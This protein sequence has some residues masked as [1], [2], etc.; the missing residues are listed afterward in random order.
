MARDPKRMALYEAIRKGQTKRQNGRRIAFFRPF[1]FGRPR[2]GRT[3]RQRSLVA[4]ALKGT[5]SGYAAR[6]RSPGILRILNGAMPRLAVVA[7]GAAVV[8]VGSVRLVGGYGVRN[9]LTRPEKNVIEQPVGGT[10]DVREILPEP[11]APRIE[12]PAVEI[13][14]PVRKTEV[15]EKP[16]QPVSD[17]KPQGTNVIVIQAYKQR[18]DLEPVME[19]FA[20]NGV[21]TEIVERGSY[22]FLV[23]KQLYQRCS[24]DRN[25]FNP[26]YDGDVARQNIQNIGKTYKAPAGYESFRPNLFQDAYAEKVR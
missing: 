23:T 11:V 17:P 24:V 3:R 19:H 13:S 26:K 18:R 10:A 25:S 16:N 9:W 7:L 14:N 5:Q 20:A 22:F 4:R 6:R 12:K 8:V 2:F 21:Q 15:S 1:G